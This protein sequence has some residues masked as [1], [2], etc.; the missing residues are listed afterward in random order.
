VLAQTPVFNKNYVSI[1][2]ARPPHYLVECG[3]R[4]IGIDYLSIGPF[5]KIRRRNTSDF[6]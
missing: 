1:T 6:C 2:T 4:T 5:G 3:I